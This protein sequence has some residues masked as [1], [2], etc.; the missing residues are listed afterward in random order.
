M[1]VRSSAS[2]SIVTV[3]PSAE[4]EP[5]GMSS[6]MQSSILASET[7]VFWSQLSA[8]SEVVFS[9]VGHFRTVMPCLAWKMSSYVLGSYVCTSMEPDPE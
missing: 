2:F 7:N 6:T 9:S 4:M 8:A 3:R 5:P 1:N